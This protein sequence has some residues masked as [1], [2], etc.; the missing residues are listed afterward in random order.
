MKMSAICTIQECNIAMQLA[1]LAYRIAPNFQG[2][3]FHNFCEG[4][5]NHIFYPWKPPSVRPC[6]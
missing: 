3:K 4:Y 6:M 2:Q 1:S 5:C